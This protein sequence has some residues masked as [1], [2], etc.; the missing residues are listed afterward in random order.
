MGT[1]DRGFWASRVYVGILIWALIVPLGWIVI[2]SS[3]PALAFSFETASIFF[4]VLAFFTAWH[5]YGYSRSSYLLFIGVT[6]LTVALLDSFSLISSPVLR[7]SI[8]LGIRHCV[9]FWAVARV[10]HAFSMFL[11]PK[12][13][14]LRR[15]S[16]RM[17]AASAF[18]AAALVAAVMWLPG[19]PELA[20]A[21]GALTSDM[22]AT[23]YLVLGVLAVSVIGQTL[24]DVRDRLVRELMTAS[25][26]VAVVSQAAFTIAGPG[27]N[28]MTA[29]VGLLGHITK[30]VSYW[31]VYEAVVVGGYEHPLARLRDGLKHVRATRRVTLWSIGDGAITT[32]K[33]GKV[34]LLNPEA[35][36]ITGWTEH[37]ALGVDIDSVFRL[38]PMGAG[39]S[40]ERRSRG[41]S[42]AQSVV[43]AKNADAEYVEYTSSPIYGPGG[44]ELGEVIVFREI[45]ERVQ[46]DELIKTSMEKYRALFEHMPNGVA[47]YRAV[48]GGDDFVFVEFNRAGEQIEGI[49][50]DCVVGRCLSEVF[51][52]LA[53]VGLVEALQRVWLTG[54]SE[55]LSPAY[56]ESG[57]CSGWRENWIYRVP[58]GEVVAVFQDVTER[59]QAE[60]RVEYLTIHDSLTGLYNRRYLEQVI[61]QMDAEAVVPVTVVFGDA[62]G[63]KLANDAFGH[64]A[65]DRLLVNV[66]RALQACSRGDDII[67]RMGGDEFV[68]IMPGVREGDAAEAVVRM[69]HAF[70][71]APADPVRVSLALGASTRLAPSVSLREVLA[72]AEKRAYRQKL[73]ESKSARGSLMKSLLG[74]LAVKTPETEDHVLRMRELA[75]ELG[76]SLGLPDSTLDDLA[77]LTLIHDIGMVGIPDTILTKV[78]APLSP[79][80]QEALKKH[81]EIGYRVARASIELAHVADGIL[82]HHENWDGSGYPQGLKGEE[83][84]LIARIV[85][86]VD[87]YD[88]M[89]AGRSYKAAISE[90][91][92]IDEIRKLAGTRF[93]PDLAEAF[94]R[95]I[96][97]AE[98]LRFG[99]VQR[100]Q[101]STVEG[102][103][104]KIGYHTS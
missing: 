16:T 45:S 70:D 61:S 38:S 59:I 65:G 54:R 12:Y 77:V 82:S 48:D 7:L 33:D 69:R 98:G 20:T 21:D 89:T 17:L 71:E 36:R 56:C 15:P 90:K 55:R 37:D 94:A 39:S 103:G 100:E 5:T 19:F 93:D 76:R 2:G 87:A 83:I 34:T 24:S 18:F 1:P 52:G 46:K 40:E 101:A 31:L 49:K 13:A 62:N 64:E 75:L 57:P 42:L 96:G 25:L 26:A 43:Y 4:A 72:D 28:Y 8:E 41:T 27:V 79:D 102:C 53:E 63:L 80:E 104:D 58:S 86:I 84:P 74:T 95:L 30:A 78:D 67:V 32:N 9:Q 11:A 97:G 14:R 73:A 99:A 3:T 44:E 50:A 6:Q 29:G 81:P 92:A 60:Q 10:I 91:Q 85:A 68:V 51:P 23:N 22:V 88:S 35:S 47:V 66:A